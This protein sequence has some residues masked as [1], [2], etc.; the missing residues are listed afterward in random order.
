M[1][2]KDTSSQAIG[3]LARYDNVANQVSLEVGC[4]KQAYKLGADESS[5]KSCVDARKIRESGGGVE[6]PRASSKTVARPHAL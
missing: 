3:T 5:L 4:D 2:E 1:V 6:E